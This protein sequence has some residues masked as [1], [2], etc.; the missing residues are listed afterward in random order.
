MATELD[1]L[2]VRG[3]DPVKAG[4]R[5]RIDDIGTWITVAWL[6]ALVS[7]AVDVLSR[8]AGISA[9][10]ALVALHLQIVMFGVVVWCD[11]IEL[12]SGQTGRGAR[13]RLV[14]ATLGATASVALHWTIDP[15][16]PTPVRVVAALAIAPI[17]LTAEMIGRWKLGCRPDMRSVRRLCG[18]WVIVAAIS[19]IAASASSGRTGIV[20]VAGIEVRALGASIVA[21]GLIGAIASTRQRDIGSPARFVTCSVL[22][23][24]TVVVAPTSPGSRVWPVVTCSSLALVMVGL[25]HLAAGVRWATNQVRP[26]VARLVSGTRTS[27]SRVR[28]AAR[29][30]TSRTARAIESRRSNTSPPVPTAPRHMSGGDRMAAIVMSGCSVAVVTAGALWAR[31]LGWQPTAHAA[32]IM[33][34][35]YDVGTANHPW[36]GMVT[37]LGTTLTA[38]H[39]GPFA[40]DLLA[41]FVRLFGVQTGALLAGSI[42]TLVGWLVAT[43]AAW[44]A[45]GRAAALAAWTMSAIVI[46]VAALGAT[47]EANNIS[48]TIL[49]MFTVFIASWATTTGTW[50]AWWWVVGLGSL[51]AQS[52]LTTAMI[53]LGPVVWSGVVLRAA[54]RQSPDESDRGAA[55]TALRVGFL[56]LFISWL[57]PAIEAAMHSGGNVRD[58]I[59][60][61]T[62]P[63]ATVGFGGMTEALAWI[64]TLPPRWHDVT[65]SFAI[66]GSADDFIGGSVLVGLAIATV[67]AVMWW[68]TRRTTSATERH[69]RILTALV[70]AGA[71][72]N[73]TQLPAEHLRSFQ[74]GW[75]VVASLCFWFTVVV[76]LGSAVLRRIARNESG[77]AVARL[78]MPALIV[79][80]L[81]VVATIATGPERIEDMKGAQFTIDAM[82]KP[83]VEQTTRHVPMGRA[84]LVLALDTRLNQG[85]TDTILSNLIVRG[86]DAKVEPDVGI[87][88]G[89]RRF[90]QAGWHGPMILV[91]NALDPIEPNGTKVASAAVPGWT[92]RRYEATLEQVTR[93]VDRAGSV[94]LEPWVEPDITRYLAGWIDHDV[95]GLADRLRAGA[96][97]AADLP[98]G[99]LLM[100]YG[101]LA[102]RSPR[103]PA[104]LQDEVSALTGQAPID[105][106]YV[107]DDR[108]GAVHSDRLLRDGSQCPAARTPG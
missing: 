10:P 102:V 7:T 2:S 20:A 53:V 18:A 24:L 3:R 74:L 60:Q 55:R 61:A 89:R 26:H 27:V 82:V 63:P 8:A 67:A 80:V 35:A 45:A 4:P 78:R 52:Y 46:E 83:L 51:C 9:V 106:W 66:A 38:S 69:L 13:G 48:L 41:P 14:L 87:H 25:P 73:V 56:I 23:L 76:S 40:I 97:N 81:V 54:A 65:A 30:T 28:T 70:I 57:Q 75:L 84:T 58:L 49:A 6:L 79:G 16:A 34:R 17:A 33:A 96:A 100:L 101:D 103:L 62:H 5:S 44:R 105:I 29:R 91:T 95:C 90:A 93:V 36:T 32:T 64:C 1:R 43:W 21:A 39:P 11:V 85:N 108:T 88:Y 71:I 94:D 42:V 22:G 99:L 15:I 104:R 37:S 19:A 72:V 50:R 47:W 107:E 86:L 12:R 31:R 77:L 68:R 59:E 98:P 92:T